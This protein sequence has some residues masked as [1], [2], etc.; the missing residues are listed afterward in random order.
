MEQKSAYWVAIQEESGILLLQL[1]V[2]HYRKGL[3]LET[4]FYIG[5]AKRQLKVHF[6]AWILN[7]HLHPYPQEVGVL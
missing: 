6:K 1:V 3:G 7:V 4:L 5:K 2:P